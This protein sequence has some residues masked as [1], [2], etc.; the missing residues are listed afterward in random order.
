MSDPI[1]FAAFAMAGLLA[2]AAPAVGQT[3]DDPASVPA[4]DPAPAAP[5]APQ[6][7]VVDGIQPGPGE[8]SMGRPVGEGNGIGTTY[9]AGEFGDWQSRCVKV[10]D[11][12]DPCQLY[13]LL[14][15]PQGNPVA[16]ISMFGLPEGQQAAAGATIITPLETLLTQQITLAVDSGAAKR[17]PFTFCAANGCF[18]RIGF[19]A[20]DVAS[21]KRG[22][23]ATITIVPAAAPDQTIELAISLSG[24][25][26]GFDGVNEANGI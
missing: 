19:T 4:E 7:R 16:E 13:Q 20:G 3:G 17:Y 22:R 6:D 14:T 2:V 12:N 8:L 21:F 23:A 25:T 15:D 1:K 18:A 5:E 10:E 24:F 11:G 26:A 9:I